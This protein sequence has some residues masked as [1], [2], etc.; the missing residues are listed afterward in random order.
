M[1]AQSAR[2]EKNRGRG[3]GERDRKQDGESAVARENDVK[4]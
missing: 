1:E 4:N 3:T 2:E